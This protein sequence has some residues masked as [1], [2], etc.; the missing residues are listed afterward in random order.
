[1]TE[2]SG[3]PPLCRPDARVLILGSMPGRE[4]LARRKYYAHPRN[5]FWPIIT[6]LLAIT[7]N[8]YQDL[9]ERVTRRGIAVWDVLKSCH[10]SGSLDSNIEDQ[11][12]VT[13]DFREFYAQHPAVT[14]VFFNG[15]KAESVYRK[16]VLP[17]L[18]GQAAAHELRRLP[19][20]SPAHA[21]MN[22]DQKKHAWRVIL[23]NGVE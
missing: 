22:F 5:S 12:I 16:H 4:S 11:S 1:M 13:N 7:V 8:D 14:R 10:R 6:D 19:S 17:D 23:G 18:R 20:T 9:V 15:A 2:V 21:G 3:F